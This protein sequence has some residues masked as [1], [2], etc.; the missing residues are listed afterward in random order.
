[1]KKGSYVINV[2]RGNTIVD[3]DLIHS[4]SN[5]HIAGAALDVFEVEPLPKDHPFWQL[6]NVMVSPHNAYNSSKHLDRVMELFLRNL[7]LF[8]DGKPLMNVVEKKLGY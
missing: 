4:L 7:K 3:E 2:G 1:M 5:G 6:E 8:S